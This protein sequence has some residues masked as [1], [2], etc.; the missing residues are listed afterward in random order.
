MSDDHRAP[1]G[2]VAVCPSCEQWI[3]ADRLELHLA[4]LDGARPECP[5]QDLTLI[6]ERA[7]QEDLIRLRAPWTRKGTWTW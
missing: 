5:R 6:V 3:P 2:D 4:G 7:R 1:R